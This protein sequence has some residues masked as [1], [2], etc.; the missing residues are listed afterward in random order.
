MTRSSLLLTILMFLSYVLYPQDSGQSK[1]K[2]TQLTQALDSVQVN[3]WNDKAYDLRTTKPDSSIFFAEKAKDLAE[4][5]NFEKGYGIALKNKGL[6]LYNKTDYSQALDLWQEALT[7]FENN[8]LKLNTSNVLNNIGSVY[9]MKGVDTKAIDY[10]FKSLKIAEELGDKKQIASCYINVGAVYANDRKT[11]SQSLETFDKAIKLA[12]EIGEYGLIGFAEFN[13]GE[14]SLNLRQLERA[15]D[16]FNKAKDAFEKINYTVYYYA[17]LGKLAKIALE[18]G[19]LNEAEK[20]LYE[21]IRFF[22][23]NDSKQEL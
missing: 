11:Y 8:N 20:D 7:I 21:I 16:H 14:I 12:E 3:I 22:E 13:I 2:E 1:A 18:S 17:A 6:A 23:A 19:N 10:F 15:T 4:K 9:Q 5:L